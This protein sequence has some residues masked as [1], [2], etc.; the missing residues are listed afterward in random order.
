MGLWM[1]LLFGFMGGLWTG[2]MGAAVEGAPHLVR[3]QPRWKI[4]GWLVVGSAITLLTLKPPS[5]A[6][7]AGPAT[8]NEL[9]NPDL[10]LRKDRAAVLEVGIVAGV[11]LGLAFG[12]RFALSAP[13]WNYMGVSSA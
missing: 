13:S 11:F 4:V 2:F 6:S 3:R 7:D 9:L 1:G 10:S 5:K 8:K 12:L